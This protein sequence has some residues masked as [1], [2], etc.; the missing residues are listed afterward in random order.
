M[1]NL[2]RIAVAMA[3]VF[4]CAAFAQTSS[5]ADQARRQRN[6]DEVLAKHHV[7]LDHMNGTMGN[8]EQ[9]MPMHHRTM[10]SRTH[11]VAEEARSKRHEIARNM[12]KDTH[13][14][15]DIARSESHSA[16]EGARDATHTIAQ[17]TRRETH[18]AADKVRDMK[19]DTA[20][21]KA[22]S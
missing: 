19:D 8:G 15:A 16:A 21:A 13:E 1:R 2:T 10:R 5:D 11:H 12:R 7:D 20:P 17:K 4:S 9:S 3:A 18:R 22:P 14:T 6:V